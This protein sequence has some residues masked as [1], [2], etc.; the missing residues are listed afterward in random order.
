LTDGTSVDDLVDLWRKL[1]A[2]ED[3]TVPI[4]VL[5]SVDA[6]AIRPSITPYEDAGIKELRNPTHYEAL[7]LFAQ[8]ITN[9][10][11]FHNFICQHWDSAYSW[12]VGCY[13]QPLIF[14]I[15]WPKMGRYSNESSKR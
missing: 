15:G 12:L 4:P 14:W 5:S 7:D 1:N 10:R 2:T 11:Q 6:V 8:F 13:S 3:F 9:P